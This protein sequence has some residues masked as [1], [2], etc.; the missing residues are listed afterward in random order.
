MNKYP[1]LL[2][3]IVIIGAISIPFLFKMQTGS[4]VTGDIISIDAAQISH[5][6][7]LIIIFAVFI[8]VILLIPL[9]TL[10]RLKN[11]DYSGGG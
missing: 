2:L 7:P 1:Y 6:A 11:Y 4:N 8:I 10:Y 9:Y 5:A 3:A